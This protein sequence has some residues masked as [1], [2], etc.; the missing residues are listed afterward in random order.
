V[1]LESAELIREHLFPRA[2]SVEPDSVTAEITDSKTERYGLRLL[3]PGSM[4]LLV[5][6]LIVALE[7]SADL[8][9]QA[10]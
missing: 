1:S 9:E 10:S 5:F 2:F 4:L 7:D 3:K 8:L 6:F